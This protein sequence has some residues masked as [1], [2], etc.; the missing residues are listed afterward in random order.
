METETKIEAQL[1]QLTVAEKVSLCHGDTNF[2]VAGIPRLGVPTLVMSDG[3]HG[4]RQELMPDGWEPMGSDDDFVTCLPVATAVAATWSVECAACFGAV[5]GSEARSRGKDVILGPGVNIHRFALCG[6]NFE[7]YSEDPVLAGEL[8]VSAIR[9]IQEQGTAACVK[10]FALNSQELCRAS[11]NAVPDE[12]ALREIYLPAFEAAVKQGGVFTVMGAYNRFRGQHCC[13]NDYLLNSILKDEWEFDGVVIS[14]WAGCH[15]TYEAAHCG[16]DIEMGTSADFDNFHLA[17]PFLEAVET[18]RIPAAY[19][20]DKARRVLRLHEKLAA[21]RATAPEPERNTPSHLA[22]ARRIAEESMVLLKNDRAVLPIRPD[23]VKRLLVVGANAALTHHAGGESSAVKALREVTPLEGLAEVYGVDGIEYEPGYPV[24]PHCEQELDCEWT[25]GFYRR[26]AAEPSETLRQQPLSVDWGRDVPE[27]YAAHLGRV[28]ATAE[29]TAPSEGVWTFAVY[30]GIHVWFGVGRE[31][32]SMAATETNPGAPNTLRVGLAAGETVTL[33]AIYRKHPLKRI[34]PLRVRVIPPG[35]EARVDHSA[36]AEKARRADAVLFIGGQTHAQDFEGCDRTDMTLHDGQNELIAA[37]AAANP[38]FAVVLTGGSAV[39]M[40]WIDQV[41]SVLL[42]WYPGSEGGRALAALVAGEA[43][44]SGKLPFTFPKRL[45]DTPPV[46][47]GDYDR[48]V[49][50]YVEG[51][52]VGYRWFDAREVEPLFCFGHGLSY[53]GFGYDALEVRLAPCAGVAVRVRCRVTNT[54]SRAGA[55]VVQLYVGDPECSTP[56]PV[57]ELKAFAKP[58]LKP[59]E[60]A[61]VEFNL[62]ERDLAF[63]EPVARRWTVEAGLF[64]FS[65]GSSSRDLRLSASAWIG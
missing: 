55:E 27:A 6:R 44:P 19:L 17:R 21:A 57:R 31:G 51:V 42:A 26:N 14:D 8:A 62:T 64:V 38:R 32:V 54:G 20:D 56:R 52:F 18:G 53:T 29:F 25:V 47:C 30:G 13:H 1:A 24:A 3:P 2:S 4:V 49:C 37:L 5:L 39:E 61:T 48:E 12:R 36:L 33:T 15:D 41:N 40:P 16:L 22:A 59:G 35:A 63:F 28:V 23:S 34:D 11:V 50:H 7:Y 10:H 46:A 65:V 43:N 45:A 60:S 9:S 58:M